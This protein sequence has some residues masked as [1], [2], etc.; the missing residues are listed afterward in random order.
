[1]VRANFLPVERGRR[2]P[3]SFK[4]MAWKT[5][6]EGE[7]ETMPFNGR[8]EPWPAAFRRSPGRESFLPFLFSPFQPFAANILIS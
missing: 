5:K 2:K 4:A 8:I 1:M 6:D 3:S 7:D